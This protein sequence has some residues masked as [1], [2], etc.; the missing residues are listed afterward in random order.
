MIR[1]VTI[2]NF[3]RFDEVEFNLP[4]HIVLAGPNNCGKT[5]VLQAIAAWGLA[6]DQWRQLYDTRKHNGAYGRKPL[7][8]QVFYSVPLRSFELLWR[9]RRYA[10]PIVIDVEHCDGWRIGMEVIPD[11][12]EQ[13]YVRPTKETDV[14]PLKDAV[15]DVAY[16]PPMSGPGTEEPVYQKPKIEQLLGLGRPGEIVR[17]LLA[18]ANQSEGH[19]RNLQNSVHR[20]FAYELLPP[21]ASVAHIVAEYREADGKQPLD[22]ASAGS[23][24]QQV[25]MLMAF[26]YTRPASILLLDEPDAHLHIILQDAIYDELRTVANREKSQLI[27]ATHAEVM[28]NAVA[29]REV[30]VLV[31]TPRMLASDEEKSALIASLTVLSNTDIM[32][33][34]IAPGILYLEGHTDLSLLREWARALDHPISGFLTTQLFW[35]PTTWPS[36]GRLPG[37]RAKDH[38]DALKLVTDELPALE[39]VDGDAGQGATPTEITGTG[40]Q[41]CRWNR[42]EIESYLLHPGGLERYVRQTVGEDAAPAHVEAMLE[43]IRENF[44]P[45]FL[46]DPFADHGLLDTA[47]A[48]SDLLPGILDAAGLPGIPYTRYHEIAAVMRPEEIHPEVTEKLD[49]IQRAFN[50]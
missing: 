26:L 39:I 49:G 21:D 27:L 1:K 47:K 48:R 16:V 15:I 34:E 46:T 8:R 17:N 36:E 44:P 38:Y 9:D 29:A 24:F 19:W 33:A 13:V 28:I 32:Q 6:L 50:L 37:V 43:H 30:C 11:S 40:F 23:G 35:K 12:T 25:L 2:K 41:R 20:M 45:K 31:R 22:I 14:G 42:Y 4:G 18:Q 3:K 7:T 5:T 10:E